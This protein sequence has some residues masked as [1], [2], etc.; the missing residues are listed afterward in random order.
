MIR[1]TAKIN[2]IKDRHPENRGPWDMVVTLFMLK[3]TKTPTHSPNRKIKFK[4]HNPQDKLSFL[5]L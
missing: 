2:A 3:Y 4:Q 5:V 1:I